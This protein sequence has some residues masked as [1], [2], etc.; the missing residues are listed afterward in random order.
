MLLFPGRK[1][2]DSSE[3]FP[4]PISGESISVRVAPDISITRPLP[5]VARRGICDF[6]GPE[7]AGRGLLDYFL[8]TRSPTKPFS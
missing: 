8:A 7:I 5:T 1:R 2:D 3:W 6:H 4:S